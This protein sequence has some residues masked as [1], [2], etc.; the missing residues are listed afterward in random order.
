MGTYRRNPFNVKANVWTSFLSSTTPEQ[1]SA[2]LSL[3]LLSSYADDPRVDPSVQSPPVTV[4]VTPSL[5]QGSLKWLE[6]PRL[7]N[8]WLRTGVR[9]YIRRV[10]DW[11]TQNSPA[12]PR[13]G[14]RQ[15]HT[16]HVIK[17]VGMNDGCCWLT[18]FVQPPCPVAVG[19]W[20]N[21]KPGNGTRGEWSVCECC[22][23]VNWQ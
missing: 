23:F 9:K 17:W 22:G 13:N 19:S 3:R 20:T 2:H 1:T 7:F 15:T 11:E 12:Q 18:L 8:F 10:V 5:A 14:Q 21:W 6:G 16:M 4:T